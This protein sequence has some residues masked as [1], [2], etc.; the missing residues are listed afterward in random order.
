MHVMHIADFSPPHGGGLVRELASLPTNLAAK[1]LTF[2]FAFPERRPWFGELDSVAEAIVL[3]EIRHPLRARFAMR[4][5]QICRERAVDM[6]HLHFSFALPLALALANAAY[7]PAVYHWHNPPRLLLP[8]RARA[9]GSWPALRAP[10]RLLVRPLVRLT[11]RRV[12]AHHVAVSHETARLLVSNHWLDAARVTVIPNAISI[13]E[14]VVHAQRD[15][16]K[17][18]STKPDLANPYSKPV[19]IGSVAAF[20]P[21]KDHATLLRAFRELL[22]THPGCRLMLVGDGPTRPAMERLCSR[23]GIA[24]AVEFCGTLADPASAYRQLDIFVLASHYEGQGIAVLEAMA[25][26]VPVVGTAVGG[27][28][29]TIS[30]GRDGLLVP[31]NDVRALLAALMNLASDSA[32]RDRLGAAGR[33][34][35]QRDFSLTGWAAALGEVYKRVLK[36][37]S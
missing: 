10:A 17:R 34:K 25:Y 28:A 20:R 2:T 12:I 19:V 6:L 4:A 15:S 18:D 3:P 36:V 7:P 30:E 35:V 1:G 8:R 14:G 23:L 27:I 24:S 21:Q 32:L 26:G 31:P 29:E 9:T 16:M 22:R 5:M 33:Q 11:D 37:G 13:P